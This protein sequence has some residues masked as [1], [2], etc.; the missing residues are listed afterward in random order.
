MLFENRKTAVARFVMLGTDRSA[1][2]LQ[3]AGEAFN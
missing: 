2:C 3:Q 1:R